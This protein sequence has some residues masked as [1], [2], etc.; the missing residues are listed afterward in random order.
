LEL[1]NRKAKQADSRDRAEQSRRV[2]KKADIVVYEST[3]Y[4]G[5]EEDCV[6]IL[7]EASG[8]VAGFVKRAG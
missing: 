6:P 7:E 4:P 1:R 3:V 2:L 8:L 5:A